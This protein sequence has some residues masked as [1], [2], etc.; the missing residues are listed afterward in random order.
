VT[1]DKWKSGLTRISPVPQSEQ[2]PPPY[3]RFADTP[4]T[5][6]VSERHAEPRNLTKLIFCRLRA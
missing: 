1:F 6:I 3:A 5:S 4:S 2:A